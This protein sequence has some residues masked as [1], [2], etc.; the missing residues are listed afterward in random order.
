MSMSS[1][2]LGSSKTSMGGGMDQAP[3][4]EN[5]EVASYKEAVVSV[6]RLARTGIML[7]R[8]DQMELKA[9][10]WLRSGSGRAWESAL[11]S[12]ILRH[13]N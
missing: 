5:L 10:S 11:W 12:Q 1:S 13:Q 8:E 9:V 2:R 3:A 6:K 7:N 4:A